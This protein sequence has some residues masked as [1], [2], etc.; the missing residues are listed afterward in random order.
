MLG[1]ML[2]LQ[3]VLIL[4]I[5]RALKLKGFVDFVAAFTNKKTIFY[6]NFVSTWTR[7]FEHSCI[8]GPFSCHIGHFL[9]FWRVLQKIMFSTSVFYIG[10]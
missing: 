9:S 5:F 3:C 1:R 6:D 10:H 2:H 7:H 4:N 8:I